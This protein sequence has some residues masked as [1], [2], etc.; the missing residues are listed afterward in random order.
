VTLNPSGI[1]TP[2]KP[3][4]Q[5][6]DEGL[7]CLQN[8]TTEGGRLLGAFN[9]AK[10]VVTEVLPLASLFKGYEEKEG[11]EFIIRSYR[12]GELA[13]VGRADS[14]L[15]AELE[16][17]GWDVFTAVPVRT[18]SQQ[19]MVAN[20]GLLDKIT[21]AAAVREWRVVDGEFEKECWVV[22][23]VIALG[24]LGIWM[25]SLPAKGIVEVSVDEEPEIPKEFWSLDEAK[26]VLKIDLVKARDG[27]DLVKARDGIDLVKARDGIDLVKARDGLYEVQKGRGKEERMDCKV[28]VRIS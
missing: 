17:G 19:T 6:G 3:W 10:S 18:S 15:V 9:L 2:L 27:I 7:C 25:S 13:I 14:Y 24:T 5:Y 21:G 28:C 26:K 1:A 20:L 22:I 11:V 23:K 8:Y 16:P 12:T 4:L